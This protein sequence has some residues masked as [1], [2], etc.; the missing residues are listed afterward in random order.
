VN[1]NWN[2]PGPAKCVDELADLWNELLS[3][4]KELAK[5]RRRLRSRILKL[6]KSRGYNKSY[7]N[8]ALVGFE[9][10]IQAVRGLSFTVNPDLARMFLRRVPRRLGAQIFRRVEHFEMIPMTPEVHEKLRELSK[11]LLRLRHAAVESKWKSPRIQVR[12]NKRAER[13]QAA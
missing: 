7:W 2:R 6:G 8:R 1:K 4:E 12:K 5:E 11:R 13:A 9:F 10:E 3:A